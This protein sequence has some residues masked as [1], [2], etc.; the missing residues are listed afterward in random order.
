MGRLAVPI[1][2]YLQSHFFFYV[3]T[4]PPLR[5]TT[6]SAVMADETFNSH[7]PVNGPKDGYKELSS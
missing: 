3:C 4:Y 7:I 2:L 5:S 6:L 1:G